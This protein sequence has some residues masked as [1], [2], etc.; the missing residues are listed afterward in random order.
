MEKEK[1]FELV[2]KVQN[3]D[4]EFFEILVREYQQELFKLIL[5]IIKNIE[6]ADDLT[7]ETFMQAFIHIKSF[8]FLASFK[9]WLIS[10]GLNITKKYLRKRKYTVEFDDNIKILYENENIRPD[11]QDLV[12]ELIKTINKEILNFPKMQRTI[13]FLRINQKMSL[14]DIAAELS[15]KIGTVK[16]HLN[17]AFMKLRKKYYTK[18]KFI[19]ND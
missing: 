14:N 5:S 13:F 6:D 9:T 19:I 10:I 4:S 2:K 8:K 12:K 18:F 3:G 15:I 17:R 11:N 7:Q 16:S 1:E